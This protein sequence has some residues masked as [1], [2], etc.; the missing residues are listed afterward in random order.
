MPLAATTLT[1]GALA[2]AAGVSVETIRFYQRRGLLSEPGRPLSGFR[3]YGNVYVARVRF[4][5]AAQ[6][7]GFTLEEIAELL[8]LEDGT[9]CGEARLLAE[10][11]LR[12]VRERLAN[13]RRVESALNQVVAECSTARG[14]TRC[15][16]ITSL[17]EA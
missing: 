11:R 15:P 4:I 16:L 3:R 12:D 2:T 9:R 13:L 14:T 5:K 6:R 1:I 10:R 8:K 7:L 17:W